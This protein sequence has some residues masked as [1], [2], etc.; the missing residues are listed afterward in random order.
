M[1]KKSTKK[2]STKKVE[3][4][5]VSKK[6]ETE[7]V[8]NK[9]IKIKSK[10]DF[11]LNFFKIAIPVI[12]III[13]MWFAFYVRSGPINLNGL[14]ANIEANL[15][16][17]IKAVITEQIN[18]QYQN[19][20]P[21][22]KQ[23][24]IDKEYQKVIDSGTF[25]YNG[26]TIVIADMVEQS[27]A[28]VKSSFQADNGQTY[29]NA[30][31][32]YHFY[33]LSSNYL[34]NGNT[35][36]SVKN[37][38]PWISYKLAP[39]GIAASKNPEFH[40]WL[41]TK[42]F[43]LNNIN[44]N[45]DVGDKTKAIFLIPAIFAML[46]VIPIYLIIRKY[47]NDLFAFFGTLTLVSIGTFVSR[48][49]AGFVDT[50]AY[51]VFFPLVIMLFL[52]YAFS[53]KNKYITSILAIIGGF[54]MG[55]F[56]W[57]WTAAWF[58]FLFASLALLGY[59]GYLILSSFIE[60]ISIK[61]IYFRLI[62]DLNVL[63]SFIISSYI[64]TYLFIKRDII[65]N[66]Y[67]AI[68]GSTSSIAGISKDYI[69]PNVLSSVAELNPASFAQIIS[70]IGGKIIFIFAMISLLFLTLDFKSKKEQFVLIKRVLVI[71]SLFWFI[72]IINGN[73]FVSLTANKAYLFLVLLFLPV[74]IGLLFSLIN[75]NKSEKLFVAILLSI[76]MAGT[77]YM[78]LNGVRFILLL[79]PAFAISFGIGL[80][81]VANI[82][83]EFISQEFEVKNKYGKIVAGFA[84]VS[85]MFVVL[86][87][88]MAKGAINIS[89]NTLPNFDDAWYSTMY[90]IRDNSQENAIITSWWDFGHF[91]AAISGRGVTF[92][93]GSQ[94]TPQA[95]WV[96]KLLMSEENVSHDILQMLICGGNQAHNTMLNMTDGTNADVVKINKIIDST[97]GKSDEETRDIVANNKYYRFTEE[98][99]DLII[100][101]LAC[102]NPAENFLITSE[103]MVGKAGVW[104]HWG[105]WDFTKKY[106]HDN[107]KTKSA[108]EI[109]E[110]IDENVTLIENY[111]AELNNIEIKAEAEDIKKQDLINQWFAPYPSYIPIQG[112][113]L[114]ACNNNNLSLSC[115]N[116][117]SVDM[118]TGKVSA[119]FSAQVI[120]KNLV[121]P[122]NSGDLEVVQ[123][124]ENGDIDVILIPSNT[125]FNVML[126]QAPLGTSLFTQ[127]F[128]LN[129]FGIKNFEKFDDV[130]SN[131]GVRVITWK[132]K[133]S[134]SEEIV[135]QLPGIN[136]SSVQLNTT[137][138]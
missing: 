62:N 29:L 38:E 2:L 64:F 82:I 24:L 65:L 21:Y 47:S 95:Y 50:D 96:G 68:L 128:Y 33:G 121:Y 26:Q 66:T 16:S 18:S 78:S 129:G 63:I 7:N 81:Y 1:A 27:K 135:N 10:I 84:I 100:S 97:F 124:D 67:E 37:G 89:E 69:W 75:E 35:G 114:Y 90:K 6:E 130:Q 104:A 131:T 85:I 87:T 42:L 109:A 77:I 45:S 94:G 4:L 106:V 61:E 14:D 99:V 55:I 115:Q 136:L 134:Q 70:S 137:V 25:E 80:Y 118:A 9:K 73:L 32:P 22:Y 119:S 56:M 52:I 117:V 74:G 49:V 123:Q 5:K 48:T 39:I 120:F 79:A 132:T 40:I 86:F 92:D 125:G 112:K 59:F 30:I 3:T 127:L 88:P 12:L 44:E 41:E 105:S 138:E 17:N 107:Y 133:W 71:F 110:N 34:K 58:L 116:G 111:I 53:F 101:Y 102:E 122:T 108:K 54:F 57:A 103:D 126:A 72:L 8:S 51:N 23:E 15:Y 20:D 36:N 91:F 113:Y 60:N 93:G 83:N 76:W 31:D 98:Q 43:Q 19:L 46:S 11:N 13:A 28:N